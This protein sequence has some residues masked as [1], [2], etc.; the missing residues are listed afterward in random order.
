MSKLYKIY[1]VTNEKILKLYVF[2]GKKQ[3][4]DG[5]KTEQ[6][7]ELLKTNPEHE[8][9]PL[10]FDKQELTNIIENNILVEF[11]PLLIH[12][13]DTIE[14]VKRKLLTILMDEFSFEEIYLFGETR[15]VI[16]P[17]RVYKSL[18]QNDKVEL[19][20]KRF[21][22]YLSNIPE[23]SLDDLV[24]KDSYTYSD[25]ISLNLKEKDYLCK[26]SIGQKLM[27]EEKYPYSVN[28]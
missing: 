22:Q 14:T 12:V 3:L 21:I 1:H 19:T 20:K 5:T 8:L 13:D 2:I 11:V 27:V 18:T 4:D 17:Q 25:I 26:M 9:F 23:V 15:K 6:L 16:D 7:S 28:P 10:I 24:D